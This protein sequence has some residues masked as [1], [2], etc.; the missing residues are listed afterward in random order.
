[1][2]VC[3]SVLGLNRTLCQLGKYSGTLSTQASLFKKIIIKMLLK[4]NIGGRG[5]KMAQWLR[6][7]IFL[8]RGPA[9]DYQPHRVSHNCL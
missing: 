8:Y 7:C 2:C 5:R 3:V 4:N 6:L 9:F 1:M